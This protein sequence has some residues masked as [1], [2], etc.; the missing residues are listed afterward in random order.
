MNS[1]IMLNY[2]FWIIDKQVVFFAD[3]LK[4]CVNVHVFVK[5]LFISI[6][7]KLNIRH[8]EY[9]ETINHSIYRILRIRIK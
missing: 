2:L 6:I 7:A 1:G 4:T 5:S 9:D 8:R 3:N